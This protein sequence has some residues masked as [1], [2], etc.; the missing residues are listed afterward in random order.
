MHCAIDFGTSNS[1]IAVP[2]DAGAMELVE[3]EPGHRTMPTAV[4]YFVEGA[5]THGPPRAFGRAAVAAYVDGIEG[6]LM[7]SMKSILGSSLVEQT[8]DVGRGRGVKYLDII[9][10]YLRHLKTMAEAQA[11]APIRRAVLGRPVFFVDDDAQRDRQAQA[12]LTSAA[13]SVGFDE[14]HFQY[15][16]IA[17]AFDHERHIDHEEIVLVADIGGGTS[18]FSIVRVGPQRAVRLDRKDDILANHGVHIAGTDFDRRV[19]LASILREF[20]YGAMGPSING[21]APRE[22]PSSVYFDLATWHL[23]NT[24]YTPQRVAELRQMR[25]FYA[26]ERPHKRLMTVVTEHLGHELAARAEQA[27]IDVAEGGATVIDLGH[28]ER[29]LTVPL[30]ERDAVQ[31]I[32]GDIERIVDAARITAAQA[33]LAASQIDALYF[34]GGSTGLRLLAQKIAAAF[35]AARAV[36][37][38]RFASVASGLAL[39]AQRLFAPG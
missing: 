17:A 14:V 16:P 7:R 8:T 13:R 21:A 4:F 10:G 9:A 31:A 29:G 3:L 22:V 6:R 30:T 23:I 28:V 32:E 12:A 26:D 1:A 36:R 11:G 33:G 34:T 25:V 39:H 2:S 24:V 38:D 20:G 5:E 37:G 35:P 18:D 15:E 27:K 19:E